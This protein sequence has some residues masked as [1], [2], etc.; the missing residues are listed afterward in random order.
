MLEPTLTVNPYEGSPTVEIVTR[1]D[2][3]NHLRYDGDDENDLLDI[4][5]AAARDHMEGYN[6]VTG[7]AFITQTWTAGYDCFPTGRRLPLPI[8]PVQSASVSYF[9]SNNAEQTFTDFSVVED[10]RGPFLYLNQT[11]NGWPATYERPDALTVTMVAGYG[12]TAASVPQAIKHALRLM[13]GHWFENREAVII[14][15]GVT[16][17]EVPKTV[18]ML[19]FNY[20]RPHN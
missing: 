16:I 9:D 1:D 10:D 11:S 20:K 17:M 5:V 14:G 15:N 18:D 4:L 12:D 13:V 3:K 7:R 8:S 6:G 19:L 2:I